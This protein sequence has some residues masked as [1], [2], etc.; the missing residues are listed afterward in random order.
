[1]IVDHRLGTSDV[2]VDLATTTDIL[3]T[4][5]LGALE[6][7]FAQVSKEI[8]VDN[9]QARKLNQLN[10]RIALLELEIKKLDDEI[11]RDKGADKRLRGLFDERTRRYKEIFELIVA[12]QTQ[13]CA[14]Y[15]PLEGHLSQANESVKR[16]AL[17]VV[18][19]VDVEAWA[20]RGEE[21]LDLRK[22]GK[23]Q[24]RGSLAN[25]ARDHLFP[26][27]V[28]GT[29][30][31]VSLAMSSFRSE[32]DEAL[33]SQSRVNLGD[34]EYGNWTLD[35]GRWLYSTDHIV[36][37][38]SFE[39]DGVPLSQ[40]SPGT[41]GIVLLLLYLA[42]DL[43]DHRPLIIDQPEENLDPRSVFTEL[44]ELFK[45]T[46]TRRQVIMVTHN[47]NLVVNTDVDQVIV[48]DCKRNGVDRPPTFTYVSGGLE[49][50]D[51]RGHVCDILEGGERAFRERARRLRV[52]Y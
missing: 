17:V 21:L 50:P 11:E 47:A 28:S 3:A 43:D 33:L 27:W 24:G 30:E 45:E 19:N 22:T 32:F 51:I 49:S 15:A 35:V 39:Y 18:R 29:A 41:R 16:L 13:L 52:R 5:S 46:R 31:E 26:A 40:L 1:M 37:T 42:L 23:F 4:A 14:L 25:F 48:A 7:A 2:T 38:Y 36:N 34:P 9:A 8:G 12:E 10:G 6:T 44:V 20:S